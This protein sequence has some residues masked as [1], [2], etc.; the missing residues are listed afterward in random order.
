MIFSDGAEANDNITLQGNDIIQN[1]RSGIRYF[2]PQ[3]RVRLEQNRITGAAMA[4]VGG[5]VPGVTVVPYT[6]GSVGYVAR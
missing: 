5:T 6:S 3:T 1:G 4:Y 2:G